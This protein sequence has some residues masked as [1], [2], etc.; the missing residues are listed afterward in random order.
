MGF[1]KDADGSFISDGNTGRTTIWISS[2][3]I[4][5]KVYSGGYAE[6]DFLPMENITIDKLKQFIQINAL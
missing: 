1:K 2:S 5:I 6:S 4:K 3:G